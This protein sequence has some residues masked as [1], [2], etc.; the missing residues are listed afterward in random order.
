M[1][2]IPASPSPLTANFWLGLLGPL[3]TH[4]VML[5]TDE[6]LVLFANDYFT[7][8]FRIPIRCTALVGMSCAS[9]AERAKGD[10]AA[11]EN[12]VAD[13][14]EH[15]RLG[16]PV[17]G[18][19]LEMKDGRKLLRH[20]KP[21]TLPDGKR[22]HLWEF[23]DVTQQW[24]MRATI[25]QADERLRHLIDTAQ[26]GII[27]MDAEGRVVEW[28]FE[29][30]RMFGWGKAEVLGRPLTEL[31]IPEEGH[32]A[33]RRGLARL[34]ASGRPE[35]IERRRVELVAVRRE[36]SRFPVELSINL[37]GFGQQILFTGFVRDIT[38]QKAAEECLRRE[39]RFNS[40]VAQIALRMNA[41]GSL[42]E[43]VSDSLK[44]IG[45]QHPELLVAFYSDKPD[46]QSFTCEAS[47]LP[48]GIPLLPERLLATER[49]GF[50]A[51]FARSWPECARFPVRQCF[52]VDAE[53]TS[54]GYFL[55]CGP[56]ATLP[57]S[58]T[59]MQGICASLS[60]G[61][62][63]KRNVSEL[64]S[65][66]AAIDAALEGIAILDAQGRY[67]YMNPAH[68]RLFGYESPR[69]LIGHDWRR[70]YRPEAIREFEAEV[71]PKLAKNG[72]WHGFPTGL[73]KDGT[74]IPEE[75]SLTVLPGGGMVCFCMDNSER[76]NAM[77]SLRTANASLQRAARFKDEVLA[78]MSHELRT[79][80]NG[81]IG[82]A[83]SLELQVYGELTPRQSRSVEV[84]I[85]SARHLLDLI[86]DILDL[87]KIEAGKLDIQK[88][89]V[90]LSKVVEST[91]CMVRASATAKRLRLFI[92]IPDDLPPLY[93]DERRLKQILVNLLDNAIKFTPEGRALGLEASFS[94]P[95]GQTSISVWDEGI[96]IA[97]DDQNR[98]FHPFVQLDTGFARRFD[99]TGLGLA[100]VHRL[101]QLL[102]GTV[103]LD[104]QEGKGSRFTLVLQQVRSEEQASGRELASPALPP[105]KPVPVRRDRNPH[106]LLV[107]DNAPNAEMLKTFLLAI[108]YRVTYADNGAT[109][110]R[111]ATQVT[112]RPDIILMDIQMPG[113]DGWETT[114][115][116]K[117]NPAT[118]GIPVLAVTALAMLEDRARCVAAGVDDY[119][120]KPLKLRELA[121]ALEK[122]VPI[123]PAT[124]L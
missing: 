42:V 73:R 14:E 110:L 112:E 30:E 114:R 93:S 122:W 113:M 103:Q 38:A 52:P 37:S 21:I 41:S 19:Q 70:I 20:Y 107:D 88:Q 56:E 12:F 24:Q 54:L 53:E 31:I 90:D 96:G 79:P 67:V 50:M 39:V 72:Y 115:Q 86:N 111:L 18:H 83:E 8:M 80:L 16:L 124:S 45:Q 49:G 35:L 1:T 109:A 6:R 43:V 108:G 55:V 94:K 65:L 58:D 4:G 25:Q 7:Q 9:M 100:L 47:Y 29:A 17:R 28:N 62:K 121:A 34:L 61:I 92:R 32:E 81:V 95:S 64:R 22:G 118:S 74:E 89:E 82:M 84:I 116:L 101:S 36:G 23:E 15:I 46:E 71:F 105:A 77:E 119:F 91:I 59:Q 11:P 60:L 120:A 117:A 99:G 48:D 13:I 85:S 68:A 40:L 76:L 27:C 97:L 123:L 44:A 98:L 69:E 104:S 33:H 10:F 5:E 102:G 78:N 2:D 87:A 106:V 57:W 66:A 63:R 3:L 51:E 26:D 75:V